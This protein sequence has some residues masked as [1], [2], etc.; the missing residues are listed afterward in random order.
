MSTVWERALEIF[1]K[2]GHRGRQHREDLAD[3]FRD[4]QT[5][6]PATITLT[7]A[8]LAVLHDA[9]V[10]VT[11]TPADDEVY[12]PLQVQTFLSNDEG[13]HDFSA[14]TLHVFW[15]DEEAEVFDPS[16]IA[17]APEDGHM[18]LAPNGDNVLATS[19]DAAAVAGMAITIKADAALPIQGAITA[20]AIGA[21]GADYEEE[22]ELI[23]PGGAT[24]RVDTVNA[25]AVA[26]YTVL[27]P[28]TGD[29]VG[30][31]QACT[32]GAGTGFEIDI[33]GLDYSVNPLTLTVKALHSTFEL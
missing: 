16:D 9:V 5:I 31:G 6:V 10:S 29:I 11:R 7:A 15:G 26:T 17:L 14:A 18:A 24:L 20:S 2:I 21:G 19:F 32:G 30:D 1:E 4:T 25:G 8:Q 27:D 3:L 13:E 23:T 12:V 28:G 33:T 22:D